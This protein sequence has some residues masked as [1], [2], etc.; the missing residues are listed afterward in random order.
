MGYLL[1]W[2]ASDR[3]T[4]TNMCYGRPLVKKPLLQVEDA[5]VYCSRKLRVSLCRCP[6]VKRQCGNY[7]QT[8]CSP[9]SNHLYFVGIAR[10]RRN[11]FRTCRTDAAHRVELNS[12]LFR[13]IPYGFGR[14]A[15]R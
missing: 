5:T 7:E 6:S 10:A 9:V 3:N 13:L 4:W 15:H 1:I 12:L 2:F 8:A 11:S 14:A